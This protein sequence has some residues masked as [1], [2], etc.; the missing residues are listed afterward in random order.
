MDNY[1]ILQ[2]LIDRSRET[3]TR[4]LNKQLSEN[5]F[6][7][8]N[9]KKIANTIIDLVSVPIQYLFIISTTQT[10][11]NPTVNVK[12]FLSVD[13]DFVFKNLDN[14]TINIVDPQLNVVEIVFR[15]I[16]HEMFSINDPHYN[17]QN[18]ESLKY[19][20]TLEIDD[21]VNNQNNDHKPLIN[22]YKTAMK[23]SKVFFHISFRTFSY[24]GHKY[25]NNIRV[26]VM[27][28]PPK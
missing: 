5:S 22:D 9:D 2:N 13:L 1:I 15:R 6:C 20:I 12:S 17:K 26:K 23:E 10:N 14:T 7:Y 4:F 18:V 28:H 27:P 11:T 21:G 3:R 25:I 8:Q 16:F 19:L 24:N